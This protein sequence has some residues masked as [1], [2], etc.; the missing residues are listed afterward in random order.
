MGMDTVINQ[1]SRRHVLNH[2]DMSRIVRIVMT[3]P[4]PLIL[5]LPRYAMELMT[6]VTDGLMKDA[7]EWRTIQFQVLMWL[8]LPLPL[9]LPKS[10][11]LFIHLRLQLH[12][13]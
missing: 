2:Q 8:S 13:P 1:L 12:L 7:R 6:T 9:P 3:V 11:S 10:F 5:E 4:L